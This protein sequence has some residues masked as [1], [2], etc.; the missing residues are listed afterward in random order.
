MIGS[1]NNYYRVLCVACGVVLINATIDSG[2]LLPLLFQG[3]LLL[4][5][6]FRFSNLFFFSILRDLVSKQK[7]K[8]N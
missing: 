6:L 2:N 8:K 4:T 1:I 5:I 3:Q 7:R